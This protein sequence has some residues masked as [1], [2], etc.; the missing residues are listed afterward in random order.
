M[1]EDKQLGQD[2]EDGGGQTAGPGE[3]GWRRTNSWA[4]RKRMEEGGVK[5][6]I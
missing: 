2:D 1:M 4:R 6:G 5:A 3:R